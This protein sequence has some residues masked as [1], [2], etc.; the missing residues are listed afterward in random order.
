LV[1]IIWA[2]IYSPVIFIS[3]VMLIIIWK[4]GNYRVRLKINKPT[5][6]SVEW[7]PKVPL[8]SSDAS[9]FVDFVGDARKK[10][11]TYTREAF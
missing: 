3:K 6:L 9:L 10:I 1:V 11:Y 2:K 4:F 5:E 8:L 7:L